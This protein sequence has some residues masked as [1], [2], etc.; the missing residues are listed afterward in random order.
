M[1]MKYGFRSILFLCIVV[2][3]TA[4]GGA[5]ERKAKYLE[6]G[7]NYFSEQNYEKAAIEFK[8][9]VQ[10]DQKSGEGYY[11]LGRVEEQRQNW[12]K[13]FGFYKKAVELDPKLIP[14]KSRLGRF[15][16]VFDKLDEAQQQLKDIY[17]L[18]ADNK[19]GKIL[20]GL[21]YAKQDK[22]QDAIDVIA[23][24]NEK[25]PDDEMV[26]TLLSSFYKKQEKYDLAIQVL[27]DGLKHIPDSLN[28]RKEL[29][30]NYTKTNDKKNIE[31][32]LKQLIDIDPNDVSGYVI[33]ASFYAKNDR[34]DEAEKVLRNFIAIDEN[35]PE[36]YIIL[37]KLLA[38][39]T[40]VKAAE[41]ELLKAI[42]NKP[43]MAELSY[44]LGKLYEKSNQ[45]DKSIEVY[46][47]I[48]KQYGLEKEGLI[49][50]DYLANIYLNQ[51][52]MQEAEKLVDE[53]LAKNPRDA[54]GLFFRSKMALSRGNATDAINSLR[55]ILKEQ[56]GSLEA[57][58]LLGD[59]YIMTKENG[60]AEEV[61]QNAIASNADNPL[62]YI[63]YS[64]FLM[65]GGRSDEALKNIDKALEIDSG[66][67]KALTQ[68]AEI[69]VNQKKYDDA[70]DVIN[71]IKKNKETINL[72]VRLLTKLYLAE[73][74]TNKAM[75]EIR[76]LLDQQ[77]DNPSLLGALV[78][79]MLSDKRYD[80]AEKEVRGRMTQANG[81]NYIHQDLLGNIYFAEKK[82]SE[83]E[84]HFKTAIKENPEW[85]RPYIGLANVYLAKDEVNKAID[86][87]KQAAN[88]V[89][90][91]RNVLTL[92]AGLYEKTEDYGK[93]IEVY[94][95]IL[96]TDPENRLAKNNFASL[97]ADHMADDESMKAKA[98]TYVKD[99]E[100]AS[101][102]AFRDTYA[103][104][105]HKTGDNQTSLKILESVVNDSP[106]VAV[107]NYHLAMAYFAIGDKVNAKTYLEKSVAS[108]QT[109]FG[110]NKAR[111]LLETL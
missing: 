66:S 77:P 39:R 85:D 101:H 41:E 71:E 24:L 7:Q 109:F 35:T 103:W 2:V 42:Q 89:E 31:K 102:P 40:S 6:R 110:K 16:V 59:A 50:R 12:T 15:Y 26:I 108:D 97:V 69:L 106:D 23:G 44:A 100:K 13:S 81:G 17:S 78:R 14:A 29:V 8:N 53:V 32:Y 25:Y 74:E 5:E 95:T 49:A 75:A 63:S 99:Y 64:K 48:V 68:K 107:F 65:V 76:S 4:C 18:D 82:L 43:D 84:A 3:I 111:D 19:E 27:Q 11:W 10:I 22:L 79:I 58:V 51:G 67:T 47:K 46:K 55:V 104:L 86:T 33:L 30:K 83:A 88:T 72:G 9:V 52:K 28:I 87:Y 105:L 60:L 92:L 94:Q 91:T 54:N 20:E 34:V 61:L 80:E 96:N 70:V 45:V 90:K 93:A 56:P 57:S 38:S 73:G 1:F 98:L 36:G 62:P 37:S 21:I